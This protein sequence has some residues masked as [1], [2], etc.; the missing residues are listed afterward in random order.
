[1]I[2]GNKGKVVAASWLGKAKTMCMMIGLT[3]TL[4]GNIPFAYINLSIDQ[5]L[6]LIATLLS[7]V[8]GCQYYYNTKDFLFPKVDTQNGKKQ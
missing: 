7:V 2:S 5:I 1:M 4:F 6:L 8:S 3:L